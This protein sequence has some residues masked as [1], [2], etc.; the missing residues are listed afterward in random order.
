MDKRVMCGR[1]LITLTLSLA[2][3]KLG[4]G[5]GTNSGIDSGI[6]SSSFVT[7]WNTD[8]TG[9]YIETARKKIKLPLNAGGTYDFVVDWGDG[10]TSRI[11]R[12][13]QKKTTH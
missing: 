13:N 2:V 11:T 9:E 4:H 10:N 6:T 7:H 3:T 1:V 8:V 5:S 12:H